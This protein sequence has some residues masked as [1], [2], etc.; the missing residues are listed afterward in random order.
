MGVKTTRQQD[1][2]IKAWHLH[3]YPS[4]ILDLTDFMDFIDFLLDH[5]GHLQTFPF[6]MSYN[7]RLS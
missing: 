6:F 2:K 3:K 5:Y 7:A 4:T 1:I